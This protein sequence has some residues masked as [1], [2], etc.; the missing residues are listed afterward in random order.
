MSSS[1]LRKADA[2]ATSG[3]SDHFQ[4]AT[5]ILPVVNETVS[6]RE[7]VDIILRDSRPDVRELLIVICGRTTPESRATVQEIQN[8]LGD[9]VVV[10]EQKLPFLGGA[11]R[12]AFDLARGSHL[13]MMASDLET[14]PEDVKTLIAESKK[15]PSAI[16]TA[17]RW[18]RGGSFEGY[19]KVKLA[20]NWAFQKFFSL[21]Y[22]T[23]LSDMTYAYRIFPT[24]LV[25]SI[26]WEE[27]RHPFLFETLVKPLRL[28]V[29][30]IEIPSAWKA[31]REGISQNTFLQ[32][33]VY[34]RTGVKTRLASRQSLLR[35]AVPRP[36]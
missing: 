11:M 23:R 36:Q 21:L 29:R 2:A 34:F 4:S 8:R 33:F 18:R 26:R 12:E 22:Q 30:V 10:H 5:I 24:R 16:I 13:V 35:P 28:G 7:T 27:L 25:Q 32:N 9:L 3:D 6:L 15:N 1:Y 19:S 17:S 20:C 31:R 14:D